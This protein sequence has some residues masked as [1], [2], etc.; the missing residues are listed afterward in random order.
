MLCGE[1]ELECT[2]NAG[3][4]A[5]VYVPATVVGRTARSVPLLARFLCSDGTCALPPALRPSQQPSFVR[6]PG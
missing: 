2:W 5:R 1:V 3:C 4:R 6:L